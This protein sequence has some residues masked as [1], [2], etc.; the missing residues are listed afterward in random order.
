LTQGDIDDSQRK[1]LAGAYELR[2]RTLQN[3]RDADA[4]ALIS[5]SC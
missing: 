4:A 2:G 5:A 1:V 3:L